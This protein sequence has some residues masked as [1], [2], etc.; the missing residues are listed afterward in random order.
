VVAIR[1]SRERMPG[2]HV[3][4]QPLSRSRFVS[5]CIDDEGRLGQLEELVMTRAGALK[6][7]SGIRFNE[8]M[9]GDGPTV[10]AHA[11]KLGLEGNCLKAQGLRLPFGPLARLAQDEDPGGFGGEEGS[12]GGLGPLSAT[13]GTLSAASH[14]TS[15]LRS[16]AF[17]SS[18]IVLAIISSVRSAGRL[19]PARAVSNAM[20]ARRAV[21]GSKVSPF[22]KGLIGTRASSSR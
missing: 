8:H 4:G 21:S 9:E 7:S 2:E 11:C 16:P 18:M 5:Y 6:A 12:G 15:T 17:A 22:K 19:M 20:P 13:V 1:V 3:R 10:F 14:K